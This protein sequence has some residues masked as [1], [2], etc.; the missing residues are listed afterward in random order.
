MRL[1]VH[2]GAPDFGLIFIMLTGEP[3]IAWA[4]I[5]AA[6]RSAGGRTVLYPAR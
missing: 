3:M 2:H 5:M 1:I 6:G 4:H